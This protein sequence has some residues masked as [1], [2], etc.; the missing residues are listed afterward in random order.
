MRLTVSI[1]INNNIG[2]SSDNLYKSIYIGKINTMIY[3]SAKRKSPIIEELHALF[4][5]RDLLFQ[6]VRRDIVA[7][8]KRSVLGVAWTML[9]PLGTMLVMYVVFSHVFNRPENYPAYILTGIT[10]WSTFTQSTTSAMKSMVWGSQLVRQ[11]Y[12][13]R[14]TFVIS[15]VLS[16][17]VNFLISLIP[18]FVILLL[19]HTPLHLSALLLPIFVIYLFSFSLGIGLLLATLATFFPDVADF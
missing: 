10:C 18:L 7:R 17:V 6:L 15:T 8:Y 14:T 11:I 12:V 16:N 13:P 4:K 19:T 5:Y 2:Q 3:D 1:D 9:N